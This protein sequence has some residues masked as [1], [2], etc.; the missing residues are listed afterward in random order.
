MSAA[1]TVHETYGLLFNACVI[2]AALYGAGI[3]QFWIYIRRYH[4]QDPWIV[5]GL[6]VAV[7][8]CDTIQQVLVSQAV[9]EYLVTSIV[10]PPFSFLWST[11][12]LQPW[13]NNSIVG[14]STKLGTAFFWLALCWTSCATLIV[15]S[16]KA[17]QLKLFSEVITLKRLSIAANT[18][19]AVA[20][21]LIS[22][23]LVI[24]LH[25]AKTGF[26][27]STD[28]INRLMVF[29]FNTGLPTSICALIAMISITVWPNTFLYIFFFLLLGRLYTNSILVT[30]NSREYI[31][32]ASEQASREHYSLEASGRARQPQG[33]TQRDAITIRIETDT[34]HDFKDVKPGRDQ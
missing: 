22:L 25:S 29:T 20:D 7:L 34:M 15:Y 24:L 17:V 19:S 9:Y 30:L 3:L 33:S 28:L 10:E 31:R 2:S 27:K 32:S 14:E 23:V 1:P 18:L 5:K 21:I 13:C 12:Q 8:I 11:A 16:V 26:K 6:V 4:S